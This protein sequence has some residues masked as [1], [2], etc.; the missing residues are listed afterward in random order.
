MVGQDVAG[1]AG[2]NQAMAKARGQ[3]ESGEQQ[4]E[5]MTDAQRM[6]QGMRAQI[7]ALNS[8]AD[9]LVAQANALRTQADA[10]KGWTDAFQRLGQ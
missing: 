3:V 5:A 4:P 8:H 6:L 9:A 10:L 2:E 1:E 7:D